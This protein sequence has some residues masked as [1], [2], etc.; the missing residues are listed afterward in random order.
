MTFHIQNQPQHGYCRC[1]T[2]P[3]EGVADMHTDARIWARPITHQP[4]FHLIGLQQQNRLQACAVACRK[5]LKIQILPN[6]S[7][8]R[9]L[10]QFDIATMWIRRHA[11]QLDDTLRR[12]RLWKLI[13]ATPCSYPPTIYQD[14]KLAAL[15]FKWGQHVISRH[16]V[17]HPVIQQYG[18]GIVK[19]AFHFHAT[20]QHTVAIKQRAANRDGGFFQ[21]R[22]VAGLQGAL[23]VGTF[24]L[25]IAQ[26]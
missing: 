23:G 18:L 10:H 11:G 19:R 4:I 24:A 26:P 13:T 5:P 2:V 20:V 15:Y 21:G 16:P 6:P 1:Q 22:I 25:P 7:L 3:L 12:W 14:G 9:A 8:R 17:V